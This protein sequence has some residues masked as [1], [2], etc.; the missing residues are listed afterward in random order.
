MRAGKFVYA[1]LEISNCREKEKGLASLLANLNLKEC[2]AI[3]GGEVVQRNQIPCVIAIVFG[4]EVL[5]RA[6]DGHS[7]KLH[8]WFLP[9]FDVS[10]I[11]G[12]ARFVNAFDG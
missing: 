6:V 7:V 11:S 12:C 4:L 5:I 3:R 10:I 9:L 1:R 8:C 2:C